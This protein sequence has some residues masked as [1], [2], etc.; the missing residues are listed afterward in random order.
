M[1]ERPATRVCRHPDCEE[2]PFFCSGPCVKEASEKLHIHNKQI[3]FISIE[4]LN[5]K[6]EEIRG[7]T[8]PHVLHKEYLDSL[9]KR[10]IILK[11]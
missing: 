9:K 10:A 7:K 8:D 1:C 4:D 6:V 5:N 11:E 3:D 2:L